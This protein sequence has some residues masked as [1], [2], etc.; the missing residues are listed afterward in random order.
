MPVI[1]HSCPVLPCSSGPQAHFAGYYEIIPWHHGGRWMLAMEA[2]PLRRYM[3][4]ED[5]AAIVLLDLHG[6]AAPRVIDTTTAWNW[7]QGAQATW[8]GPASDLIAYNVR[9]A[10][11]V[12]F[13]AR[14]RHAFRDETR[15]LPLPIYSLT[16]DGR[17][18]LGLSYQRLRYC[19]PTIGYAVRGDPTVPVGHPADD[20][21]F[22]IDLTR[23]TARLILD[24][25]RLAATGHHP[26]MEGAV[27]WIT[28]PMPDPSGRRVAFL[29]RYAHDVSAQR[30]WSFR[31]ATVGLD[32]CDLRILGG[33]VSPHAPGAADATLPADGFAWSHPHWLDDGHAMAWAGA[34]PRGYVVFADRVGVPPRIL[35]P[36][37]L[38]ANGHYSFCPT[39]HRWML[40]DTYP[41]ALGV[42]TLFL[43]RMDTGVRYN[44]A[45]FAA[46]PAQRG[47]LRCDLHPRWSRDGRTVCVDS[48]HQGTRQMYLVDVSTLTALPT[49]G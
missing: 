49:A 37:C 8:V 33:V 18:G 45:R 43:Y 42:Q 32:G 5:E 40:S 19:H 46:D 6:G 4:P 22:A 30:F 38:T 25:Q 47:H 26:S 1:E 21:L 34:G 24:L 3:E 10:D 20:G 44:V 13:H 31:L 16:A 2:P 17:T 15:D 39:D 14:V 11:G 23:G 35:G 29:H 28:H 48:T 41:D 9:A 36:D 27:H 12:S 7:Q